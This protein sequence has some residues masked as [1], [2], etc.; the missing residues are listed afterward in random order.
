MQPPTTAFRIMHRVTL[1]GNVVNSIHPGCN[2]R[3]SARSLAKMLSYFTQRTLCFI[4]LLNLRLKCCSSVCHP[5]PVGPQCPLLAT[6]CRRRRWLARRCLR[7]AVVRFRGPMDRFTFSSKECNGGGDL[8]A[9]PPVTFARSLVRHVTN[10]R[11]KG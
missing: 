8:A 5:H 9:L 6:G 2:A 4:I 3:A 11:G 10:E 1:L 7:F